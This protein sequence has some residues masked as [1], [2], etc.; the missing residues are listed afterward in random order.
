MTVDDLKSMGLTFGEARLFK[1]ESHV[2]TAKTASHGPASSH[3]LLPAAGGGGGAAAH[4]SPVQ[5]LPPPSLPPLHVER[6]LATSR[7]KPAHK[8][9]ECPE[10]Q[11]VFFDCVLSFLM[12]LCLILGAPAAAAKDLFQ[13]L[14]SESFENPQELLSQI[15]VAAVRIWT[16]TQ[17]LQGAGVPKELNVEFCSLINRALRDDIADVM[18]H[19]VVI[20]RAINALCI[21]RRESKSLK[22]P[23]NSE[24][25]RGGALPLQH[26]AFFTA[27][28]KYRV[29]MYLATSFSEDK[30]YEFW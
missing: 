22:F 7:F 14:Q 8:T 10:F 2:L 28:K 30:A 24:S 6:S 13:R 25:H 15:Q 21:V 26:H 16:S 18:P 4:T 12:T 29:P 1:E 27:G 11:H 19:L 5:P 9:A 20:V 3:T 17:K 23:P